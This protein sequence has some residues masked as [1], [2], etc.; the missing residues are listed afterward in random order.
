[1]LNILL[2]H[3]I[4]YSRYVSTTYMICSTTKYCYLFHSYAVFTGASAHSNQS[5]L[6]SCRLHIIFLRRQRN[7]KD[8]HT[9]WHWSKLPN[10][11]EIL[12]PS[13]FN[14]NG[15]W[16]KLRIWQCHE[17]VSPLVLR[18]NQ[19]QSCFLPPQKKTMEKFLVAQNTGF[20]KSLSKR[21]GLK[22]QDLHH[23][24]NRCFHVEMQCLCNV[25]NW[26][27]YVKHD[28]ASALHRI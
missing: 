7:C 24:R 28:N 6:E 22:S 15:L 3:T 26:C 25:C 8:S 14:T 19:Y 12:R 20:G 9:Q 1:M 18:Q 11:P 4:S 10:C 5:I 2:C 23:S 27:N 13:A 21:I 16:M 17:V